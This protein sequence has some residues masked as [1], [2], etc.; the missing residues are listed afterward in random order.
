MHTVFAL[1]NVS[2]RFTRR[3]YRPQS[4][5]HALAAA[6]MP[7]E[8]DEFAAL[9]GVSLTI[10][11]GEHVGVIGR[12]GAGKSTLLRVLSRVITPTE[13]GVYTNGCR[14]VV[15]LLELG[16]GFQPD[17]TG[18]ENCGLAGILMGYTRAE[19]RARLEGIA[20]FAGLGDFFDQPVRAYSSG[21]YARLAFALATDVRPEVLLVDEV[22]GVGDEF[23]MRRCMDRMQT[24]MRGGTTTVFVSHNLEFL[25]AHCERLVWL[26]K[27]RVV[28]DG[29]AGEVA[30]AYREAP[31]CT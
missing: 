4:L 3:S 29:S 24:L 5:K 9:T 7:D 12:N 18:R 14:H 10:R 28:R 20:A 26:E 30:A 22:F 1:T 8:K 16:I 13:G 6:L 31:P 23:F 19:M 17:L 25:A 27:G 2:V 11:D 21:M 15:P